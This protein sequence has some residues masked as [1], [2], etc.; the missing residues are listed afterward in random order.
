LI[1]AD[2]NRCMISMISN[3]GS[4]ASNNIDMSTG[5]LTLTGSKAGCL[6]ILSEDHVVVPP[7][8][9]LRGSL[10]CVILSTVEGSTSQPPT[11]FH[12]NNGM[13]KSKYCVD[14]LINDL[15][16]VIPEVSSISLVL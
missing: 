15:S 4:S 11:S 2:S 5:T 9:I 8:T 7:V 1:T 13:I 16:I 10:S 3:T 14:S 12:H 6:H